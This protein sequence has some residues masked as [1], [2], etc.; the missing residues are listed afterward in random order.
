MKSFFLKYHPFF[1]ILLPC[2]LAE[3]I[4]GL[5]FFAGKVLIADYLFREDD[6]NFGQ[7]DY[8]ALLIGFIEIS[9]LS[10]GVIFLWPTLK[11]NVRDMTA[12]TSELF[13]AKTRIYN[14]PSFMIVSVWTL[15]FVQHGFF[16]IMEPNFEHKFAY[17]FVA[18]LSTIVSAIVIFYSTEFLNRFL[19]IPHW[20]PDGKIKVRWKIKG[21]SLFLRFGDS[22][23]ISGILPIVSIIGI[24]YLSTVYGQNEV[25]LLERLLAITS[26]IGGIFWSLG[27][28]LT[29]LNSKT[30][31]IPIRS[32][33]TALDHYAEGK[34]TERIPVHSDDAL[35]VLEVAVNHMGEA[36][37]EKEI[38]KTL[39]GHYV[40][41]AVRDL[42]LGGKV[43]TDGDRIEAVVLFSDIRSFT[44]L[45]ETFPPER[46][47]RLLNIH[48][49]RIVEIVSKHNGF[50]DKFIGDAVMAVFDEELTSGA[51]RIS[52]LRAAAEILKELDR[53]NMEIAEL[54]FPPIRIGIGMASGPVIRGNIGSE[55]R[56]EMT[57]IGDIVN[58]ASRLESATKE[59]GSPILMTESTFDPGYTDIKSIRKISE[60]ALNIRGKSSSVKV[61]AFDLV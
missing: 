53:T 34:F 37:E 1:L 40:S 21:P 41:P 51:H 48:F 38:I 14:F 61:F 39:F 6:L 42:I 28:L 43:N 9:Y 30:F 13:R 47:V 36:L 57:V 16:L 11:R 24:L 20:F 50:V 12:S 25:G 35:G 49:G 60:E 59:F 18:T 27:A 3:V 17:V 19:L 23:L 4:A 8:E 44:S 7:A 52:A 10:L 29:V 22:F 31:L 26:I 5:T 32:M 54:G 55:N 45:S 15:G 56:R 58:L 46:I 33:Q 2:L